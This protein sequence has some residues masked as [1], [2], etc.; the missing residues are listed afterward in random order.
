MLGVFKK[1]D[2]QPIKQ[3]GMLMADQEDSSFQQDKTE[4]ALLFRLWPFLKQDRWILLGAVLLTPVIASLKLLQP[5]LIKVAV[6][7]HVL[8]GEL[9]GLSDLAFGYLATAIIAYLLSAIYTVSIS[10]SGQKML[11][12]LRKWLYE[13]VVA[14][15]SSFF[16]TQPA[17]VLLTRL[18]NDVAA[19]GE[20]IG[21]GVITIVL[22]LFMIVGCLSMMFY[23][24]LELSLLLVCI[25][26]FLVILINWMRR[27][28]RKLFLEIREA[29]AQLNAHLSEQIDGVE[30]VQI[31]SSEQR[32]MD[33][34]SERNLRFCRAQKKSN[35]YDAL[36]FAFVD[37]MSS[38][39]VGLLLWYVGS[40]FSSEFIGGSDIRTAGMMIAYI[41][42]LNRLLVPI[43][44]LSSKIAIIQ[45]ALAAL[46]KI[47]GLVDSC[48]PRSDDGC[49]I[50]DIDGS[51]SIQ[52]LTFKYT[53]DG[54][55]ILKGI[56]LEVKAGEVVAIVGSSGSGKTTLTR[57]L[58]RSYDG[59]QGSILID[60]VELKTISL[61]S[62]RKS[63][64]AVRQDIQI[65][66]D[67]ILFNVN[68][69]NPDIDRDAAN[70]AV[71]L[72]CARGFVEELGWSHVLRERGR[73]LSLGQ[74]QLLTFAR[75]MAHRPQIVILDE[76]TASV[77]SITEELIQ[78]AIERIFEHKTVIVIAHRL[79]TI[80]KAD[81]IAVMEQGFIVECGTHDELM[82]LNERYAELIEAGKNIMKEGVT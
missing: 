6:D 58:D 79:S 40:G 38:V 76:A 66:S 2:H 1:R 28:L 12:R 20:S 33:V 82:D 60:G 50:K 39:F 9:E 16:D 41:D 68:L 14:L 53:P 61:S 77:D 19:I 67:T 44:D 36:L 30:I 32:S 72:T 70:V 63:I 25:S 80:Q 42:Y 31:F 34:F 69:N 10:L 27:I 37:G 46:V 52:N 29:I 21:A 51:L 4:F 56:D 13:R 24:D 49:H 22:D 57:I 81:R 55:D 65:F 48:E 5:Y 11:L 45:R 47:F 23:L 18:T 71:D 62:L 26:P 7:D 74:G 15:P 73:D 3:R 43:R 17:G 75:A 54:P 8:T 78:K 59:Y 35:I 64:S